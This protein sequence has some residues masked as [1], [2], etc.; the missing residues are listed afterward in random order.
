LVRVEQW[1][2]CSALL[3]VMMA[4]LLWRTSHGVG[5]TAAGGLLAVFNLAVMRRTVGG[6]LHASVGKQAGL[7][8]ILVFKMGLLLTAVWAAVR[9]LGFDALG[10]ALGVSALVVGIVGGTV[11]AMQHEQVSRAQPER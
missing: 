8:V 10:V 9:V 2:L 7:S 5:S 11:H 4:A 1:V 6:F 3:L